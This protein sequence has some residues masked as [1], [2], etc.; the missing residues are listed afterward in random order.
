MPHTLIFYCKI[1]SE[2]LIVKF[3]GWHHE[4]T[5]RT[6]ITTTIRSTIR[7]FSCTCR[8]EVHR[9]STGW[10]SLFAKEKWLTKSHLRIFQ[11]YDLINSHVH[12]I[13]YFVFEQNKID[14]LHNHNNPYII[15]INSIRLTSMRNRFPLQG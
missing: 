15:M 11:F 5:I 2:V 13:M 7:A 9:A 4:V 8:T 10:S 1:D 6:T 12:K 3:F 14:E